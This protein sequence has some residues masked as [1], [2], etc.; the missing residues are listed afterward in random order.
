MEAGQDHQLRLELL[1][2]GHKRLQRAHPSVGHIM[3]ED[4]AVG[5]RCL[6][7]APAFALKEKMKPSG[8]PL[9]GRALSGESLYPL[10]TCFVLQDEV[11]LIYLLE[12][13]RRDVD[14]LV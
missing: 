3:G 11:K 1:Q 4:E 2:T 6:S 10:F 5:L 8:T 9:C 13:L 12:R 14:L 7:R